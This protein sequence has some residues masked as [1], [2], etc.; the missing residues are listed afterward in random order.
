M[1]HT[2]THKTEEATPA[3]P[4]GAIVCSCGTWWTGLGRAHCAAEGCHRTFSTDSAADKHRIGKFGV[5]RRCTDP[6]TV[7][8]V[9]AAKPYG[10]LWQHPGIDPVVTGIP[11]QWN[12]GGQS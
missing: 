2:Q 7:G 5:D 8:L 6:A 10:V 3:L 12:R 11:A 9:P 1:D 4:A